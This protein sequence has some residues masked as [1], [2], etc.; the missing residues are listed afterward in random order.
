MKRYDE[1]ILSA[2]KKKNR[3]NYSREINKDNL[4]IIF[5]ENTN[6]NNPVKNENISNKNLQQTKII[7]IISEEKDQTKNFYNI[8]SCSD[9]IFRGNL[10]ILL[11]KINERLTIKSQDKFKKI[12]TVKI[13]HNKKTGSIS[14]KKFTLR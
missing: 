9:G 14:L 3:Q 7:N 13:L 8:F 6:I 11:K 2:W 10:Y 5:T 12:K 1:F 4:K